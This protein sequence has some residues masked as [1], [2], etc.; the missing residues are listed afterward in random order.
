MGIQG[1]KNGCKLSLS[2]VC[3]DKQGDEAV[4]LPADAGTAWLGGSGLRRA[5]ILCFSCLIGFGW[6]VFSSQR[7]L[8]R[9]LS[10]AEMSVVLPIDW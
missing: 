9:W 10:G 7:C 1:S 2:V 8:I 4:G 3:V 5:R 6:K